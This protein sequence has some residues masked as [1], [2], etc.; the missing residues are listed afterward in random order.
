VS[1]ASTARIAAAS[2][3]GEGLDLA[4][5]PA[6]QPDTDSRPALRVVEARRRRRGWQV[7]T[8]AGVVLFAALFAVAGFQTLIV[9]SQKQLDDLNRDIDAA[10]TAGVRLDSQLAELQSPQRITDEATQRLG[11]VAPPGVAYLQP[12]PDDDTRAGEVP[13]PSPPPTTPTTVVRSAAAESPT[14][15]SSTSTPA[16][17]G[18]GR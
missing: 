9:S 16:S 17:G 8:V 2:R 11:M 7:G 1:R 10:T 6:V 3:R 14:A 4:P 5:G 15:P 18:A 12:R 13:E